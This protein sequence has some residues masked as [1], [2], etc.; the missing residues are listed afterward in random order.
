M[1]LRLPAPSLILQ[2][3]GIGLGLAVL[4]FAPPATGRM[5]LVPVTARADAELLPLAT[6]S[7]SLLIGP[8]PLPRSY[9]V[10]ADARL[11]A[12]T[13]GHA[14]VR[15]AAPFAGCGTAVGQ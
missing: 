6:R 10:M 3:G 8:G 7:G 1:P 2:T 15:L 9:V 11:A 4:A 13:A 12:V 5:L 14:I